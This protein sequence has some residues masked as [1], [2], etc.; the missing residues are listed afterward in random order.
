MSAP[1]QENAGEA[2][3]HE[4]SKPR[5]PDGKRPSFMGEIARQRINDP[6]WQPCIWQAIGERDNGG[7]VI[8]SGGE[9]T[10]IQRGKR[11]GQSSWKH[12]PR[13]K[14][15]QVVVTCA[16]VRMAEENYEST[17]GNCCECGGG[18]QQVA[19]IGGGGTTYRECHRCRGTGAALVSTP[20]ESK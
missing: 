7:A 4:H 1:I 15:K 9:P 2:A 12:I 14:L 20:T 11:K 6:T 19:S 16:E 3:S 17:T 8:I 13:E 5:V 10:I 18:G